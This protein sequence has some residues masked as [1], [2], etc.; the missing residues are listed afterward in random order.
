MF[1]ATTI[2]ASMA[3]EET[4]NDR[5]AF[6]RNRNEMEDGGKTLSWLP[7]RNSNASS[8]GKKVS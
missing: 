8:K 2:A 3:V 1:R 6:L 7:A 4:G 5:R